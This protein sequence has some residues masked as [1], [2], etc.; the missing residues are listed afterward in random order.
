MQRLT[1]SKLV[2]LPC[3]AL[4]ACALQQV[5]PAP[6]QPE[7]SQSSFLQRSLT[8]IRTRDLL[9]Q[10]NID[11]ATWPPARWTPEQ[12][13]LAALE[14][15]PASAQARARAG[16][17]QAQL[18]TA[19]LAPRTALSPE[20]ER[21]NER[22]PGQ[23]AW[24]V[25]LA[26]D[27]ALTG[28][29]VREARI[30]RARLLADAALLDEADAAWSIRSAAQRAL[31][32][33]WSSTAEMKLLDRL[34]VTLLEAQA[35]MQKRYDLGA[36]DALELTTTRTAAAQA[37]SRFVL[38]EQRQIRARGELAQ[39]LALPLSAI[40]ALQIDFSEFEQPSALP[41]RD[42]LRAGATL[43]RIDL[44]RALAQHAAAE[45]ALQVELRAQYPEIR[46][47]P[48]LLW[49]QGATVWQLGASLPL[50]GAE[51][52]AGPIAE[53]VARRELAAQDFLALQAQA[54]VSLEHA[55]ARV[56]ASELDTD[57]A[58]AEHD[59]ARLQATR[60][61]QRFARGDADRLD[62][63]LA[64]ARVIESDLRLLYARQ[65]TLAS[66]LAL[67]DAIQRPLSRLSTEPAPPAR[68]A[69]P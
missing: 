21:T 38:A 11:V 41:P 57:G 39:A 54:L 6:L 24:S 45:A 68:E 19:G 61:E 60:T 10:R 35:V 20:I 26:L 43:D 59:E 23:S 33:L 29:S 3:L 52:Q 64:R 28:A 27:I 32:E 42:A 66:R 15:H 2:L 18:Q 50:F 47:R 67:E 62:R 36:A 16:L 14:H 5:P 22:D 63:L 25:G 12:L 55:R 51:R 4:C 49:D 58:E 40:D 44:R 37:E 31:T 46:L 1:P 34:V 17:A 69:K 8:D 48:G 13:T 56:A 65:R 9:V 7:R 30:E 53:A